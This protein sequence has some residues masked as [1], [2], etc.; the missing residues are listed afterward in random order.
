MLMTMASV[1]HDPEMNE[2]YQKLVAA[3][4]KTCDRTVVVIHSLDELLEAS[5]ARRE[6][7][8]V[9]DGIVEVC[10]LEHEADKVQDQLVKLLYSRGM[11]WP[12]PHFILWTKIV[13]ETGA[14]A[15]AAERAANR[16]R[17]MTSR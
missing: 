17:M 2:L 15:N 12:A 6:L 14:V 9:R 11:T 7:E 5:F 10:L 8:L 16:L 3:V 4:L 1:P 13:E